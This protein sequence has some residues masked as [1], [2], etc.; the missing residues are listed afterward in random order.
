MLNYELSENEFIDLF[1]EHNRSEN[2]NWEARKALF[3]HL[4]SV[5]EDIG[6]NLTV[7]IIALCC[8]FKQLNKDE[9]ADQLGPDGEIIAK[10]HDGTV[11][12]REG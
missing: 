1:D 9:V 8:D 11:L 5:S 4:E 10:L 2:F 3:D 6:E 7:D 12:V